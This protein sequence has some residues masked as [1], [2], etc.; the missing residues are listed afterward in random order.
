VN[1]SALVL[2]PGKVSVFEGGRISA[3]APFPPMLPGDDQ[4]ISIGPDSSVCIERCQKRSQGVTGV[5]ELKS[6]D[7]STPDATD[8][9]VLVNRIS[10]STTYKMKNNGDVPVKK[11]YV[12]HT[13]SPAHGGFTITTTEGASK[14]T[15][16]FTRF[17]KSLLPEEEIEMVV[18]EEATYE[19]A[20]RGV[21]HVKTFLAERAPALLQAELLSP[22]LMGALEDLVR[23]QQLLAVLDSCIQH[24]SLDPVG[25]RTTMS[26][27]SDWGALL[28]ACEQVQTL[29]AQRAETRRSIDTLKS[30]TSAIVTSQER[31]RANIK[32]LEKMPGSDLMARY[33]RDLDREEDDLIQTRTKLEELNAELNGHS[34]ELEGKWLD[35]QRIAKALRKGF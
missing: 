30:H 7:P 14:R 3:H 4:L 20:I 15:V 13:A 6:D 22:S 1:D 5:V 16:G 29:N 26:L 31:L 19:T 32:S 17:E 33:M 10:L 25:W 28:A 2:A 8:G 27:P 9:V 11:L 35:L 18:D 21:S 12:N 34:D 24:G 23:R